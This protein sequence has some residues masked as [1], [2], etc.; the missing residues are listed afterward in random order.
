MFS[1]CSSVGLLTAVLTQKHLYC[2]FCR[3][4]YCWALGNCFC[5][6]NTQLL[7]LSLLLLN[8]LS[9]QSKQFEFKLTKK[10]YLEGQT[11]QSSIGCSSQTGLFPQSPHRLLGSNPL[12]LTVQPAKGTKHDKTNTGMGGI[13]KLPEGIS[14][15]GY[16]FQ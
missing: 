13:L 3:H 9:H 7:L 4:R 2:D 10:V 1:Y 11:P 6:C 12:L 16:A 14:V 8:R 5:L 15:N